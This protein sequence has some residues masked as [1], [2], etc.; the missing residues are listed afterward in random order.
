MEWAGSLTGSGHPLVGRYYIGESLSAGQVVAWAGLAGNG[1][2]GDPVTVNDFANSLGVLL[3]GD[4]TYSTTTGSGGVLGECTLDPLGIL[5]GRASGGPTT[6]TAWATGT[7]ANLLTQDSAS[8][9]VLTEADVG[10]AEYIGGYQI[11]L[12]GVNKGHVRV[13]D[14]HS[15]DTSQTVDDPFDAADTA[16]DTYI[17]TP[18]PFIRGLE[19]TTDFV[20]WNSLHTTTIDLPDTLEVAVYSVWFGGHQIDGVISP[21]RTRNKFALIDSETNPSVLYECTMTEH[22]FGNVLA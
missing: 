10:K 2:I 17:R 16:G 18:A 6:G 20:E 14:S 11:G 5:R 19:F 12:T 4:L 7:D 22:A 1:E 15:D 13:I 21:N 9:T 3:S 8:A